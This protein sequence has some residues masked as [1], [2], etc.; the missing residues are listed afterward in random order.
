[1]EQKAF[2]NTEPIEQFVN[3]IGADTVFGTPITENGATLIPVAQ[4]EF[5][6][7]YGGG[8]GQVSGSAEQATEEQAEEQRQRN[9]EKRAAKQKK[10]EAENTARLEREAK[11]QRDVTKPKQATSKTP[12][13]S[14]R[15][16]EWRKVARNIESLRS[17]C[18]LVIFIQAISVIIML[19]N[20]RN[21]SLPSLAFVF[22]SIVPVWVVATLCQMLNLYCLDRADANE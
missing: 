7:G 11:I 13:E 10:R 5:G 6:F 1:M 17:L 16:G 21:I 9:A 2:V 12:S 4:V 22:G 18:H 8:Y 20:L 3:R 19:T 15:A 14:E